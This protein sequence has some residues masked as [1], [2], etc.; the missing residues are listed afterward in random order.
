MA[1]WLTNPTRNHEVAGSISGLA[2]RVKDPA[3]EKGKRQKKKKE[4]ECSSLAQGPSGLKAP[5]VQQLQHRSQVQLGFNPWP[6]NLPTHRCAHKIFFFFAQ[7]YL[8]V[9]F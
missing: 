8:C 7:I 4:S 2:Q 5:E 9:F 1:Q 3:L 6:G